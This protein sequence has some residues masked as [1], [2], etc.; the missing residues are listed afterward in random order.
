MIFFFLFIFFRIGRNV[1]KFSSV[2]NFGFSFSSF[3]FIWNGYR[4]CSKLIILEHRK[5]G[6]RRCVWKISHGF[7]FLLKLFLNCFV[8]WKVSFLTFS[9]FFHF[10]VSMLSPN[11]EKMLVFCS[12]INEIPNRSIRER[13]C[14]LWKKEFWKKKFNRSQRFHSFARFFFWFVCWHMG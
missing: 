5:M 3:C 14:C 13:N 6:E 9:D 8:N 2:I 10:F 12:R 4:W 11:I 7:S 1:A